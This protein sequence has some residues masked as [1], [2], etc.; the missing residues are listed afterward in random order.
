[1]FAV[2]TPDGARL[3]ETM[4]K[5]LTGGDPIVARGM[6][7]NPYQFDPTHTAVLVTNHKPQ[8][9]GTDHALWRRVHLIP[10]TVTIPDAEK[11]KALPGKLNAER[12]GILAWLVEGCLDWQRQQGLKPP[13]EVIAA[14][15]EYRSAEDVLGA[16]L[17]EC[18]ELGPRLEASSKSLY[19]AYTT[20][21]EENGEFI[22]SQKKLGKALR[23]RGLGWQHRN[24]GNWWIGVALRSEEGVFGDE[25][26]DR[27]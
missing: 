6:R 18:C 22:L 15:A 25:V 8:V 23:E 2:E 14:T 10:F 1:V 11:D 12:Q 21:A 9:R 7:Q 3:D 27:E 5:E 19:G 26:N 20:W 24:D 16:F 17:D 4:V 13:P